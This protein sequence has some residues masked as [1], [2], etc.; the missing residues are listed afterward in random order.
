AT[1]HLL[2][3][4]F[5]GVLWFTLIVTLFSTSLGLMIT[6][7]GILLLVLTIM[8]GRAIGAAERARARALLGADLP[9]FP[10]IRPTGTF[11]QRSK[12]V[13][14]DGAGWRGMG[15]AILDLP[16]SIITFTLT[17]TMWCI[18]LPL[19]FFPIYVWFL[20]ENKDGGT[21]HFG[22]TYVL[23]G[24]GRFWYTVGVT[25]VGILFLIAAPRV[26]RGLARA[27]LWLV[28]SILSPSPR[29]LLEQ[30]VEQL[31]VSRDASV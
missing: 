1:L 31:T 11:W 14:A 17:V 28:K 29:A 22:E 15:F 20:P 13:F 23:Y 25:V 18:S 26:V 8:T 7:V 5:F 10:P 21:H 30:R 27:D 19:A 24:W 9:A 3:N 6:L 12:K 2:L 4:L 16:W